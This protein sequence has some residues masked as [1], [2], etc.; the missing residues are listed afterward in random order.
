MP[1]EIELLQ[2]HVKKTQEIFT[3]H[4]QAML[5]AAHSHSQGYSATG[6]MKIFQGAR[7]AVRGCAQ[8]AQ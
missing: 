4:K 3:Y 8:A 5:H 7:S 2:N 6:K 1:Q